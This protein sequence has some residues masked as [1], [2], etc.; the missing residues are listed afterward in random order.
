MKL[1][2]FKLKWNG[3]RMLCRPYRTN[4]SQ[5]RMCMCVYTIKKRYKFLIVCDWYN[6]LQKERYYNII[7]EKAY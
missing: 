2:N 1:S 6:V 3:M 5:P 4:D 7:V